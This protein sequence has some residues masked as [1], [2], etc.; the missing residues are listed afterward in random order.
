M[1]TRSSRRPK[2]K[3]RKPLSSKSKGSWL[4]V[5]AAATALVVP[6]WMGFLLLRS[7]AP[8]VQPLHLSTN[9]CSYPV[10]SGA[11][12]PIGEFFVERRTIVPWEEFGEPLVNA[13]VAAEDGDFFVHRGV[14]IF[15]IAR[16]FWKV[17][18]AGS[19]VQGGSTITQQVAKNLFLS[20]EKTIWRKIREVV[21]AVELERELTKEEILTL[22][23]NQIYWG[24]GRYGAFEASQFYFQ[25]HPSQLSIAESA[26]LAAV[27]RS[28]EN[29]SPY[30]DPEKCM[31]IRNFILSQLTERGEITKEEFE[32]AVRETA[33]NPSRESTKVLW[34]DSYLDHVE[35]EL[36]EIFPRGE[37][38][39]AGYQ[40]H[41][42]LDRKLQESAFRELSLGLKDSPQGVQAGWVAIDNRTGGVLASFGGRHRNRG[43]FHRGI[44]AKRPVG[45]LA[46]P[47]VFGLGLGEL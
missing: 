13:V 23:L 17:V 2:S 7:T 38:K 10:F 5:F 37:L 34:A 4:L 27:I 25:K 1:P 29:L 26:T 33:P 39:R 32:E 36:R 35:A 16:A 41:T 40:I 31:A 42:R 19:F 22:Y 15:S 6:L 45:S 8:S 14:D 46:K 12:E 30:R 44:D 47:F 21:L 24:H 43:D 11:G 18:R 3:K 20:S 28:P 9:C